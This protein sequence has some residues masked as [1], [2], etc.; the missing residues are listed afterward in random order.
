MGGPHELAGAA[1]PATRPE[2]GPGTTALLLGALAVPLAFV[3]VLYV[4]GAVPCAVVAVLRSRRARALVAEGRATNAA[5][6][7]WGL[8]L[9]AL[10]LVI[11]GLNLAVAVYLA[12]QVAGSS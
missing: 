7:R 4:V 6:A 11:A 5:S 12:V 10:A 3:P 8:W 9:A 1:G 2:N